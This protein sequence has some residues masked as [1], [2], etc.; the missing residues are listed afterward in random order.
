MSLIRA[1]LSYPDEMRMIASG[2][3]SQ[4]AARG[5]RKPGLACAARVNGDSLD[6]HIMHNPCTVHMP[7]V[8]AQLEG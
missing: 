4:R 6:A 1:I 2:Q 3:G 7:A 5:K 8:R